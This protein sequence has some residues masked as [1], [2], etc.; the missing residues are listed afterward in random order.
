MDW[1]AIGECKDVRIVLCLPVLDELD[2]KKS[3]PRLGAR[4]QRAIKEIESA[5]ESGR[6][7][8]GQVISVLTKLGDQS[9]NNDSVI[10]STVKQYSEVNLGEMIA[11]ATEDIGMKVRCRAADIRLLTP[12]ADSRLENPA[13]E[14]Q[15]KIRSLQNE[16]ESLK[17][18]LPQLSL[19]LRAD[20]KE[21]ASE[22]LKFEIGEPDVCDIDALVEAEAHRFPKRRLP[23]K[24]ETSHGTIRAVLIDVLGDE[25]NVNA[26]YNR[27]VD[28][29]LKEYREAANKANAIRLLLSRTVTFE[30]V[31]KNDGRG[32]ATAID[33]GMTISGSCFRVFEVGSDDADFLVHPKIPKPPSIRSLYSDL[34]YLSN[35]QLARAVYTGLQPNAV[36]VDG[37]EISFR[38]AT[39]KHGHDRSLAS[40]HVVFD[41]IN[42]A[43]PLAARGERCCL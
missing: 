16:N 10:V 35:V 14:L 20:P 33:I 28:R 32:I 3:D 31:L 9:N 19:L 41:S 22:H 1:P 38:V 40:F 17:N 24:K 7:I 18:R 36:S 26:D 30:I 42:D 12:P 13:D 37:S 25:M 29:Y 4:A 21:T 43:K 23:D 27:D 8:S 2:A 11:I 5:L 15:K 6:L 34:S 39:L